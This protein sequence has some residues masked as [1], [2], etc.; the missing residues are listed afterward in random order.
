MAIIAVLISSISQIL[1][2]KSA[3]K[4]QDSIWKEYINP[5]VISGYTFFVLATLL[6]VLAM[7]KISVQDSAMIE[8]LGYFFVLI[9]G[10][11]LLGEKIT[12]GKLAGNVVILL[13]I[14]L[15]YL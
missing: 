6:M 12:K 10:K 5:Y 1:L 14:C 8:S 3:E 4:S 11:V 7:K 13:G 2:K 9:L 15:Y